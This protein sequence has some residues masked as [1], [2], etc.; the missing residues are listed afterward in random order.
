MTH[1]VYVV[2]AF[3]DRPFAGNAAAVV[4]LDA[5]LPEDT[6]QAIAA[7]LALSETAFIVPKRRDYQIR[8]F[9]PTVEV[10][11]CGHATLAAAFIVFRELEPQRQDVTF[12]SRSGPL[13]VQRDGDKIV[14]D[15]PERVAR[16]VEVSGAVIAALGV[17]DLGVAAA[18]VEHLRARIEVIVL[19]TADAVRR[20]TPDFVALARASAIPVAVTAPGAAGDADYVLRFFA[21]NQGILEDPVTGSSHCSLAPYWAKRLRKTTLVARQLSARGGFSWIEALPDRVLIAGHAVMT[22]RGEIYPQAR[23]TATP[24]ARPRASAS[25]PPR[26]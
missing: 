15:F 6:M 20:L 22:L 10:D 1:S 12:D 5:W 11:L 13:A 16:P 17:A 4:P 26:A 19:P 18:Q 21:P 23:G 24:S 14:L 9:T 2:D 8:W 25:R 7:E 3:T